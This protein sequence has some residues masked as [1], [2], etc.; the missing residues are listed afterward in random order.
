MLFVKS[1]SK[2]NPNPLTIA[3]LGT[4]ALS[5]Y[6]ASELQKAGH[7]L[8]LIC[9]P[10]EADEYNATDFIFKD[11]RRLQNHRQ[12]FRCSF[13]LEDTPQLLL[14]ASEQ[15]RL[16]S[17]L[18]LLSPARLTDCR[19]VSFTPAQPSG[20]LSDVLGCPVVNAYF[21]GWLA[22]DK[23]HI[24]L[25]SSRSNIVFSLE[26]HSSQTVFLQDAFIG[27]TIE[28]GAA[29]DNAANFWRWFTPRIMAALLDF[30]SGK[31]IYSFGK[32]AEGRKILDSSIKEI[33]TL[34]AA[35]NVRLDSAEILPQL[36]NIPD[37]YA[38]Y[39]SVK[40]AEKALELE[41]LNAL[42]FSG[43]AADDRRFPV[44]RG[45]LRQIRNKC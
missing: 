31:N 27:T 14:I 2:T 37:N 17:D 21:N 19:V 10:R 38:P 28:T 16:R 25:L 39:P 9:T 15:S 30:S 8:N 35:D 26:E 5:F 3:V 44:L 20:L 24:T 42:L 40:A 7:R 13:E 33:I 4:S 43:V 22:K 32:T 36:Y 18:L 34:A 23:N 12:T 1:D 11:G 41:R 6:L 45:L 29:A